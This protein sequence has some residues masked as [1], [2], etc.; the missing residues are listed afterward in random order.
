MLGRLPNYWLSAI[1]KS[2]SGWQVSEARIAECKNCNEQQRREYQCQRM[3]QHL[4]LFNLQID[5]VTVAAGNNGG[6]VRPQVL[7]PGIHRVTE[8]GGTGTSLGD[9]STEFGASCAADGTVAIGPDELLACTITNYDNLGGC[10]SQRPHC[11]EAGDGRE[12]CRLCIASGQ[13][14]P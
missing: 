13:Q 5:G 2:T 4:R 14:C 7:T 10:P 8:T 12:G 3:P 11:C 6:V 1:G 9:F